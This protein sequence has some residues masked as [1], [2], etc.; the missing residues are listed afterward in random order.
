MP[1][2]DNLK[3][4]GLTKISTKGQLFDKLWKNYKTQ[5]KTGGSKKDLADATGFPKQRV[6]LFFDGQW[7][8]I[9]QED[10]TKFLD[11]IEMPFKA[12]VLFMDKAGLVLTVDDDIGAIGPVAGTEPLKKKEPE[13]K[14]KWTNRPPPEDPEKKKKTKLTVV[15][16]TEESLIVS[17]DASTKELSIY[18]NEAK[19][20][21][22]LD[23]KKIKNHLARGAVQFGKDI[24]TSP[25]KVE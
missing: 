19:I 12:F 21:N 1:W 23:K 4:R 16:Y 3:L 18:Y 2:Y 9:T 7:E 5:T 6:Q 24:E 25:V 8:D 15:N 17:F 22:A 20:K 11:Q 13:N 10:L 14:V